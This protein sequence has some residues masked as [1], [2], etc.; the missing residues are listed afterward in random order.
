LHRLRL[1]LFAVERAVG[2]DVIGPTAILI[3]RIGA[4][5]VT[6]RV[7]AWASPFRCLR[8]PDS[9]PTVTFALVIVVYE[10][11]IF[12]LFFFPVFVPITFIPVVLVVVAR[13]VVSWRRASTRQSLAS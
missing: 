3:G 10:R 6:V 1:A 2:L 8:T 4:V 12:P 7:M 13:I 9:G 11:I 5:V